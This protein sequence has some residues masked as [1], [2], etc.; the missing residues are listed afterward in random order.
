MTNAV[1]YNPFH[2][3]RLAI[4]AIVLCLLA[5][6]ARGDD[7]SNRD[8]RDRKARAALALASTHANGSPGLPGPAVA[9]MPRVAAQSYA[10]GYTEAVADVQPLVVF[11]SCPVE[12]VAGA[13]VAKSESASRASP[14]RP[15][16]SGS[17]RGSAVHRGR[18]TRPAGRRAGA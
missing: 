13:I 8:A 7:K 16:W 10:A 1:A 15:S 2:G 4:A 11:V 5:V 17:P 12:P 18:A 9:P 3:P 6:F 14:A